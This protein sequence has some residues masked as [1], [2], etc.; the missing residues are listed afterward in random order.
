MAGRFDVADTHACGEADYEQLDCADP[1]ICDIVTQL[2]ASP[3][4]VASEAVFRAM[5]GA[6][7]RLTDDQLAS[8]AASEVVPCD[9][10]PPRSPRMP[11]RTLPRLTPRELA[12]AALL[13][14][15]STM[16]AR[17]HLLRRQPPP[18]VWSAAGTRP[19]CR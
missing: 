3:P 8:L 17:G 10:P 7:G 19:L 4:A 15:A 6:P 11:P 1:C 16:R 13:G 5:H 14:V 18:S 12:P 9:R 2:L